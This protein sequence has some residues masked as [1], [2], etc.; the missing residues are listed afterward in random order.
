MPIFIGQYGCGLAGP[1]E[2]SLQPFCLYTCRHSLA[3][4]EPL[5]LRCTT[6]RS[7][8]N[9]VLL[10]SKLAFFR[11]KYLL[12]SIGCITLSTPLTSLQLGLYHQHANKV[13]RKLH[14]HSVM[15]ANKLVT[16]RRTIESKNTS[17]SQVTEPGASNKPPDPH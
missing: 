8:Y 15:Y 1:V 17:R 16:T 11:V 5:E 2:I 4:K 12:P 13:A 14:A 9:G 10:A 6:G 7:R 3:S